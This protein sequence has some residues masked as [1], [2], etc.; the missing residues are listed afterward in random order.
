MSLIR[1]LGDEKILFP[2]S[3]PKFDTWE[4]RKFLSSPLGR[5]GELS[6]FSVGFSGWVL[7]YSSLVV[8]KLKGRK[9]DNLVISLAL[10]LHV[11]R[12]AWSNPPEGSS[13]IYHMYARSHE[14]RKVRNR[15]WGTGFREGLQFS[16]EIGIKQHAVCWLRH[17]S[18]LWL[19]CLKEFKSSDCMGSYE[20]EFWILSWGRQSVLDTQSL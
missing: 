19:V 5:Q 11:S 14:S 10:S 18:Q 8:S 2:G 13:A 7:P 16:P 4:G 3:W 12:Q 6:S 17:Q 9:S 20:P 15:E 1:G